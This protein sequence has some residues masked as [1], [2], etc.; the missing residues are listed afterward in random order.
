M[1]QL[2][3][4]LQRMGLHGELD[5]PLGLYLRD[6]PP[7]AIIARMLNNLREIHSM[8]GQEFALTEVQR[9][10]DILG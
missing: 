2:E 7:R 6:A 4:H 9:R 8:Q 5:M 10:L 1:E 3:P